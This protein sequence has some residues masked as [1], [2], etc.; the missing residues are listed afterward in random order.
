MHTTVIG[1]SPTSPTDKAG[2]MAQE[3]AEM[4]DLKQLVHFPTREGNTLD[5][6]FSDITGKATVAQQG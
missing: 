4:F 3:F 1:S 5:V 2:L 6:T